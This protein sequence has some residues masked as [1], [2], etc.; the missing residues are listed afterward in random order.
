MTGRTFISG[1]NSSYGGIGGIAYRAGNTASNGRPQAWQIHA[2]E[3]TTLHAGMTRRNV[4]NGY[5][6][7]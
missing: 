6:S 5:G 4:R 2:L 3:T 1:I 7:M